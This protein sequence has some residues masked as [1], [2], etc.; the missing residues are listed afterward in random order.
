MILRKGNYYGEQNV[1]KA[2]NGILLSQYNYTVD[3]TEWHYHEN[4]YF[5]YVL[6][7]NMIDGNA[8]TETQCPLGILMFTHWQERHY[9]VKRSK[10]AN[11]FH[12]ELEGNWLAGYGL[13]T[14]LLEGSKKIE[15]PQLH[16]LFA[17]LYHEFTQADNYTPLAVEAL[18]VQI[19]EGLA[20][21][22]ETA[23]STRPPWIEGLRPM[24]AT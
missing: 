7:G 14:N 16:F 10:V 13:N 11:G 22:K 23:A 15:D 4:P 2:V 6:Q 12:L 5:M 21:V 1:A 24:L 18:V 17:K 19:A 8:T 9:G 20:I 3:R